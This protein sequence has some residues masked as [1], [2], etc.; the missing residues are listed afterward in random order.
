M[1][2]D[3]RFGQ[4]TANHGDEACSDAIGGQIEC[5]RVVKWSA[6]SHGIPIG[7]PTKNWNQY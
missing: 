6:I 7:I 1:H 4:F 5:K 2:R 3:V